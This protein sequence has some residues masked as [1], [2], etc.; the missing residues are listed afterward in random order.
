MHKF[1]VVLVVGLW[2]IPAQA[3]D[4]PAIKTAIEK[5]T[6]ALKGF[7]H[8]QLPP[9]A[10]HG[11]GGAGMCGLALLEAGVLTSDP[12]VQRIATFVRAEVWSQWQI[13]QVAPVVMFLD[14][15]GEPGDTLLIQVMACRIAAGQGTTGGWG[16]PAPMLDE[17]VS[18]RFRAAGSSWTGGLHPDVQRLGP[19][20][21]QQQAM[22][23]P[24]YDF[25]NTQFALLALW[26]A[27][28]HGVATENLLA[29]AEAGARRLMLPGG[30]WPYME[31]EAATPPMTC[32]GL[33]VLVT[34]YGA[35]IGVTT[36]RAGG[37]PTAPTAPLPRPGG[38]NPL[39]GD[40]K[41]DPQVRAGLNFLGKA[42]SSGG[43]AVAGD[44][45]FL[46]SLERVGVIYGLDKIGDVNWY[47]WGTAYLLRT[48]GM[49][50]GWSSAGGRANTTGRPDVETAFALL[51]LC[52]A[53]QL[54]ELTTHMKG[55]K[56]PDSVV[57]TPPPAE[58]KPA[59]MPK[60]T[61]PTTPPPVKPDQPMPMPPTPAPMPADVNVQPADADVA[62]LAADLINAKPAQQA[63][64]I[65]QYQEAR[66]SNYT[67]AL[68][69]GCARLTGEMQKKARQALADRLSNMKANTLREKLQETDVEIRRAAALACAIKEDK[70]HVPDLITALGDRESLVVKAAR[71]ALKSLTS[72]DFGP[73]ADAPPA[74]R[75]AAQAQ[76]RTWWAK[77]PASKP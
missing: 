30:G 46:W 60:P 2:A 36:M 35:R 57:K 44:L 15:L 1:G 73:A 70:A 19:W 75:A 25:S 42:M 31:G 77:Q 13:Y 54:R 43:D 69:R 64:L 3:A 37:R 63:V 26:A 6:K 72:Q 8:A 59:P 53:D 28:R 51:F 20:V 18:A 67:E 76:W 61:T 66:G 56:L 58:V 74:E 10:Q 47:D 39:V 41:N 71:A 40:L 32:A 29:K 17:A 62:K 4:A 48:Q 22:Q 45:Y 9:G 21:A 16:Y 7:G 50:G 65:E 34:G 27:R 49:D 55:G 5:G 14:R 68:A 38:G 11:P 24:T 33:L 23:G 12:V 52:K